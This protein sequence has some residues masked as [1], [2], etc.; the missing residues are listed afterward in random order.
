MPLEQLLGGLTFRRNSGRLSLYR[1]GR[2]E[3]SYA[4]FY[5]A[6]ALAVQQITIKCMVLYRVGLIHSMKSPVLYRGELSYAMFY[7]ACALVVQKI[8]NA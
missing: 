1:L 8:L 3:L 5:G 2:G 7:G 4:M 6:C